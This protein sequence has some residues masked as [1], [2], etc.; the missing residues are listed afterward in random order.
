MFS[1]PHLKWKDEHMDKHDDTTEIISRTLTPYWSY[2]IQ[3]CR[4]L[5]DP[6]QLHNVIY[7]QMYS[8]NVQTLLGASDV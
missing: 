1:V 8:A 4:S 7:I 5:R 3:F 6:V 2:A